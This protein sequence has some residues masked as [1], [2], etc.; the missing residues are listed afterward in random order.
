MLKKFSW[1]IALLI[2]LTFVFIACQERSEDSSQGE[3]KCSKCEGDVYSCLC[4]PDGAIVLGA[5]N[6]EGGEHT[7][8]N[9]QG[10]SNNA[11]RSVRD[12][13]TAKRFV[14]MFENAPNSDFIF[15][16]QSSGW[17]GWN[18]RKLEYVWGHNRF[19]S[20]TGVTWGNDNKKVTV[21]MISA[22][23]RDHAAF[24]SK[25]DGDYANLI[26]VYSA[27]KSIPISNLGEITAYLILADPVRCPD[28]GEFDCKCDECSECKKDPC[29]CF[30]EGA[31]VLGEFNWD[32]ADDQYKD[33]I[34]GW[35]LNGPQ[36][37]IFKNSTELVLRFENRLTGSL[38]LMFNGDGFD[39]SIQ[40]FLV[41]TPE[42]V[43]TPSAGVTLSDNRK[44]IIVDIERVLGSNYNSLQASEEWS[45]LVLMYWGAGG[46][47]LFHLGEIFAFLKVVLCPACDKFPCECPC[48]DC[49]FFPCE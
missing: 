24:A 23:G 13:V 41:D 22:L 15:V 21:D 16:F 47:S 38:R 25:P 17:D 42:G 37:A 3:D 28:C 31:F 9:Q 10:W 39:S 34:K 36:T 35:D 14:I 45:S 11:D 43:F 5:F 7:N 2:V 29:H 8:E 30:P 46:A 18:E 44:E 40:E 4:I 32:Y 33:N 27:D 6:W 26:I 48:T 1:I 12:I 49:G 20:L 19:S